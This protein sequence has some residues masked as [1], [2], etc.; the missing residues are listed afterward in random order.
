MK[1]KVESYKTVCDHCWKTFENGAGVVCWT[2][3]IDGSEICN[4]AL[5]AG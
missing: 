3:D 4:E 2:E 5:A 1:V